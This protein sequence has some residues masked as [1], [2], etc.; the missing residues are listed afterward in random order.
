M[1]V[2]LWGTLNLVGESLQVARIRGGQLGEVLGKCCAFPF[3]VLKNI[4]IQR[5]TKKHHLSRKNPLRTPAAIRKYPL[6]GGAEAHNGTPDGHD[7]TLRGE[8]L[9]G[10]E[11]KI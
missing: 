11:A 7:D 6:T 1:G 10:S 5:K 8:V 3:N 9:K 4:G 2:S